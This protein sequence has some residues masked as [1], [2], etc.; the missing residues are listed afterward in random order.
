MS[1]LHVY[2]HATTCASQ[3]CFGLVEDNV[4]A[5]LLTMDQVSMNAICEWRRFFPVWWAVVRF[6]PSGEAWFCCAL[7]SAIHVFMCGNSL[8]YALFVVRDR[9]DDVLP[10]RQRSSLAALQQL[11]RAAL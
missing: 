5:C 11:L 10:E 2:H 7:N 3:K 9:F 8:V 1:F 6:G 4:S